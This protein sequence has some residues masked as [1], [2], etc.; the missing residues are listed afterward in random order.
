MHMTFW[1]TEFDGYFGIMGFHRSS[2][3]G[4]AAIGGN[5][6]PFTLRVSQT[7]NPSLHITSL[8]LFLHP[9]P[10]KRN[11]R[12]YHISTSIPLSPGKKNIEFQHP[13]IFP[14]IFGKESF[15]PISLTKN[16]KNIDPHPSNPSINIHGITS[17]VEPTH[18]GLPLSWQLLERGGR[19]VRKAQTA[20]RCDPCGLLKMPGGGW[21]FLLGMLGEILSQ[22]GQY[23]GSVILS[24]GWFS[25]WW[26]VCKRVYK[27]W[28]EIF[29]QDLWSWMS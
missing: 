24:L 4:F 10:P 19:F 25:F 9:P 18:R 28:F 22:D 7:C 20:P 3:M 15:P 16:P 29:S 11:I 26:D 1:C 5:L 17:A 2:K 21:V 8:S 27:C 6:R 23:V 12:N 13:S 14:Y